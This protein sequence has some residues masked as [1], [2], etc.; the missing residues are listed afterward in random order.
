MAQSLHD[1][2][3]ALMSGQFLAQRD[4]TT[5]KNVVFMDPIFRATRMRSL[6]S[7]EL[8]KARATTRNL[9]WR[10]VAIHG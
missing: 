9:I 7:V 10:L 4:P 8:G 1:G 6:K 2:H 5:H 3:W